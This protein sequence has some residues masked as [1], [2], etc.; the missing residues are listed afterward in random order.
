MM[1]KKKQSKGVRMSD[2]EKPEKKEDRSSARAYLAGSG[3]YAKRREERETEENKLVEE[4]VAENEAMKT[5]LLTEM[6]R[7]LID[8]AI[9]QKWWTKLQ[10]AVESMVL[11]PDTQTIMLLLTRDEKDEDVWTVEAVVSPER[12]KGTKYFKVDFGDKSK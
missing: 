1:P 10:K 4:T 12:G 3:Y 2:D 7:F 5:N 6:N 8:I 11:N 9:S